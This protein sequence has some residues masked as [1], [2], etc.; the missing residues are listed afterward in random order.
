MVEGNIF[1]T[2]D[3]SSSTLINS[4]QLLILRL[5]SIINALV[6]DGRKVIVIGQV[7][8]PRQN[9]IDCI[10]RA[11][12]NKTDE[13]ICG[14]SPIS[15][16]AETELQVDKTLAAAVQGT[17]DTEIIFPYKHLCKDGT[18]QLVVGDRLI[19]MDETHLSAAGAR[20]ASIDLEQS[21]A[22]ALGLRP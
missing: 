18:C 7:P 21:L 17:L 5:R 15:D 19:Y 14:S 20:L 11:R 12:F 2:L 9:P 6:N 1:L 22:T 13:S 16:R 10:A 8:L 3:G 4:R